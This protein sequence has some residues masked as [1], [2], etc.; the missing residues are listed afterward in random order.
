MPRLN[1]FR[2]RQQDPIVCTCAICGM[3]IFDPDEGEVCRECQKKKEEEDDERT[4]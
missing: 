3:E 1:P 2:D 4:N